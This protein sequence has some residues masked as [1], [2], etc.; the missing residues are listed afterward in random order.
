[1]RT[2]TIANR[3]FLTEM[4]CRFMVAVI[5]EK[6]ERRWVRSAGSVYIRIDAASSDPPKEFLPRSVSAEVAVFGCMKLA[7]A[8]ECR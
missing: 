1:M 4:D 3:I 5:S 8:G 2:R 6:A 7:W